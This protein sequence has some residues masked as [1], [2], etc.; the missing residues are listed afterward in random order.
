VNLELQRLEQARTA[1]E[2][3]PIAQQAGIPP[4][5]FLVADQAGHVVWTIA[6]RIPKR[7]GT[8]DPE[9]PADWSKP[10]SGWDGWLQ[11]DAVPVIADPP[12]SRFWTANQRV[13]GG[14]A[15]ATLGDGGYDLGA[16]AGQIRDDLLARRHFAPADMLAI[17]LDDRALFLQHWKDLLTRELDRAPASALHTRMR[18]A[19]G[20]WN[21]RAAIDSVAYR[22]V[23]AWRDEVSDTVLDA[24]AGVVR[25]KFPD[26]TLPKLPRGE[27]A[28]WALL[29]TRPKNLLPPDYTDWDGL[30]IACADRV[31]QRLDAQPGG[32]AARSWGERNTTHIAYPLSRA[33][34]GFLARFLDMPPLPLPGDHDMPR[35]QA[36]AFGAS[37]R[38]AVAP[39]DEQHGYFEMPGGQSGHPLSPYYGAGHG[40]WAE[41]KPTPFLP[42]P[43]Q[44]TLH[45]TPG[46]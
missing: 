10:G 34:P 38:F 39:G 29:E 27:Y 7:Q 25:K 4:Q 13:V 21:G 15:L 35:V 3:I 18:K 5:N 6:G 8:A 20:D 45:F 9:L 42:G 36:P 30:L 24:F 17:Q 22:L 2:A 1:A 14:A 19:L 26:F 11:A 37:E 33:L 23:R 31:A 12:G 16:R 32:L 41:G 28:V 44:H 40:D 46:R 43:A